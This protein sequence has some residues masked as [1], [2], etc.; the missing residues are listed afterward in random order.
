MIGSL[1][2]DSRH[3]SRAWA[4]RSGLTHLSLKF[5]LPSRFIPELLVEIEETP[6]IGRQRADFLVCVGGGASG[7]ARSTRRLG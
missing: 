2:V 4:T 6:V 3:F 7:G 5:A 1:T